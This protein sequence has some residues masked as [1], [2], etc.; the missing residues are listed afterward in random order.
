VDLSAEKQFGREGRLSLTLA[1]EVLNL[2]NQRDKTVGATS[3]AS[4]NSSFNVDR[5]MRYGITGPA[6]NDPDFLQYGNVYELTGFFDF[7]REV[8]L[9][10][11]IRW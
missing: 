11:R 8:R 7:P 1:V 9:G 3:G 6:P 10:V 4:Q 2:F 5:Y